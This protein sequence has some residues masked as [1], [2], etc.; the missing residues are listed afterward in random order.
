MVTPIW[1]PLH[2][3]SFPTIDARSSPIFEISGST[4]FSNDKTPTLHNISKCLLVPAPM[5]ILPSHVLNAYSRPK[6]NNIFICD[7]DTLAV[8]NQFLAGFRVSNKVNFQNYF[9]NKLIKWFFL[10][11]SKTLA[12]RVLRVWNTQLSPRVLNTIKHC[13]SCF[14]N[15]RCMWL[16]RC[17]SP[18]KPGRTGL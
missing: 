11:L 2:G 7:K 5:I 12:A 14:K 8:L 9:A 1:P 13:C 3:F 15:G 17:L 10:K 18:L 16:A 4:S 6:N